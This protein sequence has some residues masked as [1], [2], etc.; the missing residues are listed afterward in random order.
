MESCDIYIK[1]V[2]YKESAW[3]DDPDVLLESIFNNLNE[4][5]R[6]YFVSM[7]L[8]MV[9][10]YNVNLKMSNYDSMVLYLKGVKYKSEEFLSF[11]FVEEM[12]EKIKQQLNY[13]DDFNF[14]AIEVRSSK[15][16]TDKDLGI[17]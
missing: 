8:N 15:L 14:G 11:N 12:I 16:Y 6:F 7:A 9:Q 17:T 4:I 5:S 2:M 1:S 10:A 13:I 3:T